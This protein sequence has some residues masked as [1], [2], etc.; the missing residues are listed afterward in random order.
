[1][2]L[3]TPFRVAVT[4]AVALEPPLLTAANT[5]LAALA[6]TVTDDGTTTAVLLL[7]RAIEVDCGI[8]VLSVTVQL[9]EVEPNSIVG[10]HAKEE[11]AAVA[12]GTVTLPPAPVTVT[13]VPVGEDASVLLTIIDVVCVAA[14]LTTATTPSVMA[15]LLIPYAIHVYDPVPLVHESDFPAAVSAAP[16]LTEMLDT[17]ACGNWSVHSSAVT[18]LPPE[19]NARF[20]EAVCAVV[21][22]DRLSVCAAA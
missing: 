11:R 8:A 12:P 5:A 17:D 9:L 10:V 22:D 15:V 13:A 3:E 1:M 19:A 18:L 4:F 20:K 2:V 6:G 14:T 16:A 21:A 7:L